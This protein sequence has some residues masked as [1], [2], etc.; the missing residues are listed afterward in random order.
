MK[1]SVQLTRFALVGV[2][3]TGLHVFVVGLMSQVFGFSQLASNVFAYVLASSFSFIL[4]S[5]WSFQVKP[6][7][8]RFARFQ[9]VGMIGV[10]ISAFFGYLGD[11][12]AWHYVLTGLLTACFVPLISFLG[13]RAY[14]YSR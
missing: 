8:H 1:V 3:N 5:I 2:L 14:T 4:N 11:V 10:V 7:A 12:F 9:L 13:H 6:K